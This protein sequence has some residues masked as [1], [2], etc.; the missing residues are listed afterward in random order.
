MLNQKQIEELL[1][2][3]CPK[4]AAR[5]T[6]KAVKYQIKNPKSE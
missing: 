4:D 5:L 6:K 2:C 1:K 3:A